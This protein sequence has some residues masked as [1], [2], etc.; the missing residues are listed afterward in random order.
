M[1]FETEYFTCMQLLHVLYDPLKP[2]RK[3]FLHPWLLRQ[4]ILRV[5]NF[6]TCYTTRWN[7][8]H[9][10]NRI[11]FVSMYAQYQDELHH[12]SLP[13]RT[14]QSYQLGGGA[15][16]KAAKWRT[17]QRKLYNINPQTARSRVRA[18]T[19]WT[20]ASS[21][22][23]NADTK[24]RPRRNDVG[25]NLYLSFSF[26]LPASSLDHQ[27]PEVLL[28][29]IPNNDT[30]TNHSV[31]STTTANLWLCYSPAPNC[32]CIDMPFNTRRRAEHNRS[33]LLFCWKTNEAILSRSLFTTE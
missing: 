31:Q 26:P 1:A 19:V 3:L 6:C 32:R 15:G 25:N 33:I 18:R 30:Y 24:L 4:N 16:P 12:T 27:L 7:H 13:T 23:S 29:L 20:K 22:Y 28:P 21:Q 17:H 14:S 5:C 2:P 11:L 9:T 8:S 10:F